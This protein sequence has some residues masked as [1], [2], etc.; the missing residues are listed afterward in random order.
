MDCSFE[1]IPF[2]HETCGENVVEN[3]MV[4]LGYQ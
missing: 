4:R 3:S 1:G 2:K